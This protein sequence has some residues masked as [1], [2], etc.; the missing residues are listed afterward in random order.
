MNAYV[1]NQEMKIIFNSDLLYATSLIKDK[2][3]RQVCKFLSA[4]K[5]NSHEIII[6]FT[7]LLEFNRKQSEFVNTE[8]SALENARSKL[9][10]YGIKVDEFQP[11]DLVK[12][13][14]LIQLI[15]DTGL[16]CILEE[17]TKNDYENAHRRA[18]L[19][20]SPHPP[21]IKSDEMRDLAYLG[22]FYKNCQKK[23]GSHSY[24]SR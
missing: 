14:D 17:P 9:T 22:N 16:S 10:H 1:S 7:T 11:L 3:P 18:C 5:E 20:E 4:C 21:N 13:P 12:L 23:Q 19:R 2:L 6:P 24:E 15:K 8:I